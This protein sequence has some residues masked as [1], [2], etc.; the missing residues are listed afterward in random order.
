MKHYVI[1]T[2]GKITTYF[3]GPQNE[4]DHPGV[5]TVDGSDDIYH[6]FYNGLSDADKGGIPEPE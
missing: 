3:G 6:D 1:I 2:D 4:D 5:E